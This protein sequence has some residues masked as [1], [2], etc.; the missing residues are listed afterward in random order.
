M[1]PKR[2]EKKKPIYQREEFY[3]QD[4]QNKFWDIIVEKIIEAFVV[5]NYLHYVTFMYTQTTYDL[6]IYSNIKYKYRINLDENIT[7][8]IIDVYSSSTQSKKFEYYNGNL[9][10]I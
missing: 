5:P 1:K 8:S 3:N 9:Y 4:G 6:Y 7:V 10:E 2:I